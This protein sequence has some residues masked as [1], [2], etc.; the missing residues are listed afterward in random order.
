MDSKLKETIKNPKLRYL[1]TKPLTKRLKEFTNVNS[2]LKALNTLE[3]S[4]H[5]ERRFQGTLPEIELELRELK[6]Q[7]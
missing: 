3:Q 7:M 5:K 1:L 6:N 4:P 2:L